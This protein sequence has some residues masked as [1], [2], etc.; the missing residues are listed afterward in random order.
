MG[1]PVVIRNKLTNRLEEFSV[2]LET[3]AGPAW[4][5]GLKAVKKNTLESLHDTLKLALH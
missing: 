2:N 5:F 1:R 3:E 4:G